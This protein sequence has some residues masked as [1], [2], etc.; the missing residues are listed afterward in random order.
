MTLQRNHASCPMDAL[1]RVLMGPWT[2][3][4]LW[5]LRQN[6][7]LRFGALK[8]AVPGISSRVLTQRLRTLEEA[9]IILRRYEPT[10]PPKVTYHLSERGRELGAVLDD[11]NDIA[12]RWGL[13]GDAD[14]KLAAQ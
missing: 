9:G 3:Y 1:L 6:G 10:I 5:I 4:I 2:T 11:L 14:E 8:R 7:E 13:A 12:R